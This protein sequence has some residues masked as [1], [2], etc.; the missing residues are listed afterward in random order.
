MDENLMK[1]VHDMKNPVYGIQNYAKDIQTSIKTKNNEIMDSFECINDEIIVLE[2]LI[3]TIRYAFKLKNNMSLDEVKT[4]VDVKKLC[5]SL[6]NNNK[7]QCEKSL[8][9]LDIIIDK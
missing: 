3:E 9:K 4:E 1:I 2:N 6:L 8:D 7:M 5:K